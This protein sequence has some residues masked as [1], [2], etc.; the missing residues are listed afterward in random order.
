MLVSAASSYIGGGLYCI[1]ILIPKK[2]SISFLMFVF[3]FCILVLIIESC[4]FVFL[5]LNDVC[6]VSAGN[7]DVGGGL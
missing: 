5:H 2:N 1:C 3:A 4:I 6:V 7:S